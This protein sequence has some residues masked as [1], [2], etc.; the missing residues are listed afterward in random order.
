MSATLDAKPITTVDHPEPAAG[1]A[2]LALS[3]ADRKHA[4]VKKRLGAAKPLQKS[5]I[6]LSNDSEKKSYAKDL[7]AAVKE[8]H[9]EGTLT[10]VVMNRVSRAQDL[11]KELESLKKAKAK[12]EPWKAELALIHSRFRLT[13]RK[14]QEK[15]LFADAEPGPGRIVVATQAIEAGVDVSAATMF[16]ELA[17]WSSLVQRFGRCNRGGE[18]SDA[19]VIWIDATLKDDKDKVALPYEAAEFNTSRQF[20]LGLKDVGPGAL[21]AVRDER[22]APIVHTLRRKDLVELWDTTPD[23]AGNDLDISRFIRDADNN[24][25]QIYWR[26]WDRTARTGRPPKFEDKREQAARFPSPELP[27]LCSVSMIAIRQFID[28][29]ANEKDA[30]RRFAAW[31]WNPRDA[32]WDL[33]ASKAIRPGMVLLLHVEASGYDSQSGWTGDASAKVPLVATRFNIEQESNSDD[34]LGDRPEDLPTHLRNVANQVIGLRDAFKSLPP[35][36][37]WDAIIRA[38]WWHDVGKAHEA[39]QTAMHDSPLVSTLDPAKQQLWAKSGSKMRPDYRVKDERRS[40]F[41]HELVSA[42]AWLYHHSDNDHANLIAY[43]IASHHGK[44]RLSIRSLPN[45]KQPLDPKLR[46]ARGVRQGD[47]LPN[48]E[49]GGPSCDV[50]MPF[51]LNLELMELGQSSSGPS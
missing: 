51:N 25:V 20:L 16:T 35:D 50:S 11:L 32:D 8:A 23:L 31:R 46:Y 10:L 22:P 41:R 19:R 1:F 30:R 5:K 15:I 33:I 36:I 7:A 3:D 34:A 26:E 40:G 44:V 45:E 14:T 4:P 37:P 24:D 9:R 48:V 49:I 12:V 43:L 47:P 39:F 13:D 21:E 29:L 17:P 18:F 42:L 38:G 27:E 28:K 2:R 6:V